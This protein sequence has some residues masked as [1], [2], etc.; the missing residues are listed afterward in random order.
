MYGG[1]GAM[2]PYMPGAVATP[3]AVQDKGK[4][5]IQDSDFQAAFDQAA[6]SL[7]SAH[8]PQESSRIEEI[9][10]ELE[11]TQLDDAT[12]EPSFKE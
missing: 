8:A 4:G 12:K 2:S 9:T 10:N 5:K 11:A 1:M 3:M 6:A 7:K